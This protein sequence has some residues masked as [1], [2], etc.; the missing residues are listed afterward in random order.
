QVV[1]R[2]ASEYQKTI[3]SASGANARQSGLKRQEANRNAVD[4]ATTNRMASTTVIAPRGSSRLA[5]RGLSA[6]ILA[7]T[8][9]LKPIAALRADTMA[10]RIQPTTGHVIRACRD[11]SSAPAN[12]KGSAN[13][14]W[15]KRT[16]ARY[17]P[18][19]VS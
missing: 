13:A 1:K 16:N 6:S 4:A 8:R 17:V 2:F 18:K 11:A 10:T 12:A 5:V 9:R 14:E 3:A 7:S 15:L 19:R